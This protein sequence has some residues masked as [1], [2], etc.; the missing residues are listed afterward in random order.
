MDSHKSENTAYK[1]NASKQTKTQPPKKKKK[2]EEKRNIP[3]KTK[4]VQTAVKRLPTPHPPKKK[5]ER[6]GEGGGQFCM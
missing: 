2:K 3:H 1:L 5:K 6:G 4:V